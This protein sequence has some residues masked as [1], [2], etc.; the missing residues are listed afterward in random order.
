[1]TITRYVCYECVKRAGCTLPARFTWYIQKPPYTQP[2]TGRA[3]RLTLEESCYVCEQE[4]KFI[5]EVDL[6]EPLIV[7]DEQAF[8]RTLEAGGRYVEDEPVVRVTEGSDWLR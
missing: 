2:E 7:L 3:V 5:V 6:V 4:C 8:L 1:M